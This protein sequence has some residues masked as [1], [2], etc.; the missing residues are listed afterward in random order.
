MKKIF[1]ILTISIFSIFIFAS[2]LSAQ[3]PATDSPNIREKVQQKVEQVLKNPK[4]YLGTV[5]DISGSTLQIKTESGEIKQI[6]VK[7]EEVIVIKTGKTNKE[8][9]LSDIAIGDFTVAMGYKNGNGVLDGRRIL[10]T[11]PLVLPSRRTYLGIIT[12][13][14]KNLVTIKTVKDGQEIE[15]TPATGISVTTTSSG[16]TTNVKFSSLEE[17]NKILAVGTIE[18]SNLELEAR[19]IQLIE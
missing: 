16:K 14:A 8:V 15:I 19:R 17:G 6:S 2:T 18:K 5:T 11:S 1:S 9:K 13:V 10:I 7:E 4:A 12:K 3:E